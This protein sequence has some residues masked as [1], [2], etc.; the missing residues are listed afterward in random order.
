MA[1]SSTADWEVRLL[2]FHKL[3]LQAFEND[4]CGHGDTDFQRSGTFPLVE[5]AKAHEKNDKVLS[6]TGSKTHW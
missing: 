3:D 2:A 1:I 6:G 5:K 4:K